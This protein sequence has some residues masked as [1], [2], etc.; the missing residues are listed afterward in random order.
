MNSADSY[1][2]KD[3]NTYRIVN[4]DPATIL[5]HIRDSDYGD[6]NLVVYPCLPQF[7]EFYSECC[8]DSILERNEIFVVS[9]HYSMFVR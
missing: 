3:N 2:D 9:T 5:K 6:H 7:E 8:K 1:F 4:A